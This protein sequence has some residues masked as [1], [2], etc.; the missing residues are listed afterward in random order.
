MK[1]YYWNLLYF[2]LLLTVI[3]APLAEFRAKTAFPLRFTVLSNAAV[4]I[5][6]VVKHGCFCGISVGNVNFR[7]AKERFASVITEF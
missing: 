6:C 7:G 3:C 4:S 2:M 1:P 5:D